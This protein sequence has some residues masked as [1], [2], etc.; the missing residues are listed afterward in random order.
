MAIF[1]HELAQV[2]PGMMMQYWQAIEQHLLPLT[3]GRPLKPLGMWRTELRHTEMLWLWAADNWQAFA[4]QRM[5]N[6]LSP[7]MARWVYEIGVPFRDGWV[8]K[9]MTPATFSPA[10]ERI[11]ADAPMR[12]ELYLHRTVQVRPHQVEEYLRLVEEDFRPMM[13]RY[14]FTLV[15]CWLTAEGTGSHGEVLVMCNVEDWRR[16]GAYQE[17]SRTQRDHRDF[18]EQERELSDSVED[19][20]L[21]PAPFS[22]MG[23]GGW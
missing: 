17:H 2:K 18:Y 1:L 9:L 14:G 7:E 16:W 8:D 12:G 5:H 20:L 22:P 10:A 4:E 19:R 23:M 21:Q 3:V 11:L 13:L 15:G 6:D